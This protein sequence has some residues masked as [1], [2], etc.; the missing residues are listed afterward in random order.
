MRRL[1]GGAVARA[2]GREQVAGVG[3]VGLEDGLVLGGG[4]VGVAGLGGVDEQDV[5]HGRGDLLLP[6][7]R[8]GGAA[9]DRGAIFFFEGRSKTVDQ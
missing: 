7:S 4:G 3:A 2:P 1:Q 9:I 6:G 8:T 5:L